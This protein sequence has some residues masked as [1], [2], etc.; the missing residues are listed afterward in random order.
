MAIEAVLFDYGQTLVTFEFPRAELLAVLERARPWL[1][2]SAPSAEWLMFHVLQP[3]EAGLESFGEDEVDYAAY[4]AAAWRRV[5]LNPSPEVLDRILDLEQQC[6]DRAVEVAPGAL[7]LLDRLRARGIRTGLASN[8]PFPPALLAR[9]VNGNGI[10]QRMDVVVFSSAVGRRKPAPE[11]YQAA[12][13]QLGVAPAH[14]LYVGDK[15]REDYEGPRAIGMEA[16]ICTQLSATAV[17]APVPSI[18]RLEDLEGL[19]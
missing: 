18:G 12:L 15:V 1:G 3:L 14:A 9:Q 4:Y 17:P 8:A 11:L 10:G 2:A 16:V 13:D 6:W 7:G 19:L 5:G